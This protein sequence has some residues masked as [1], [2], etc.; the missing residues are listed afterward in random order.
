MH[1]LAVLP[2]RAGLGCENHAPKG[3]VYPLPACS[4]ARAMKTVMYPVVTVS[5]VTAVQQRPRTCSPNAES[6]VHTL[7][8]RKAVGGND[9][10]AGMVFG[11]ALACDA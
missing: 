7:L 1:F 5:H 9:G 10:T 2:L 11:T 4:S 6:G 8:L 3:V